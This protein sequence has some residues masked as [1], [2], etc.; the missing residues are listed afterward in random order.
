MVIN[1]NLPGPSID[2]CKHDRIIVDVTNHL[3]GSESTIHWHGL[4][5]KETPWMDGVPMLTQ[6]PISS[7][8]TFRYDFNARQSG[9]HLYHAHS[10]LHRS[11]GIIG[12]LIVR[13]TND[14][15]A[16]FYDFDLFDHSII[17]TD[18]NN[19]LA[20]ENAPGIREAQPDSIL[21][22]GFGSYFFRE[23]NQFSYAPIA[24]FYVQRGKK[25]RIRIENAG[26]HECPFEFS[27][28]NFFFSQEFSTFFLKS[29]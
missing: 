16:Q 5:H 29:N 11:N 25:H 7:G 1:Q 18:W 28:C 22:N 8:N 9:T 12:K 15:N 13:D 19:E 27:V 23:L 26:T 20:E 21:I 17:L 6:C 4:H 24:A 14:T 10:G 3:A 2:C